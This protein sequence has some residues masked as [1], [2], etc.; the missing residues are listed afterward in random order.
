[1]DKVRFEISGPLGILTLANPPLNLFSGEVIEEVKRN[2]WSAMNDFV[3]GGALQ[4][5][6]RITANSITSNYAAEEIAETVTFADTIGFLST[7]EVALI[8]G[9]QDIANEILEKMKERQTKKE[10]TTKAQRGSAR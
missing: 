7:S 1:M 9:R 6:R 5:S 3:H 2:S 10:S 4:V 8:A